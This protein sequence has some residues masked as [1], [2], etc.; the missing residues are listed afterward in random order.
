VTR[1]L[2]FT[3][4]SLAIVV[5]AALEIP[6]GVENARS[7]RRDLTAKVERDAVSVASLSESFVEHERAADLRAVR[8]L[9]RRYAASTGSRVVIVDANGLGIVDTNPPAA[10]RRSFASRPEFAIALQGRVATGTRHST[11]LGSSF[12]YVAVP[13]AS[14]GKILGAVRVTYP[15]ATLDARVRRYWLVLAA[16]AAVVLAVALIVGV[17]FARW[18]RRPLR[19]IERAAS[20]VSGGDLA[21]RAAIP[22]G[23]PELRA[24]TS[25]FNEMVVKLES[26]VAA[27][28]D[29]VAD[30]SHELRTPLTALRLRLENLESEIGTAGRPGLEAALTE[31][32]RLSELVESLLA[33]ARADAGGVAPTSV[34]LVAIARERVETWRA[35][36]EE[37]GVRLDLVETAVSPVR[38]GA[39]RVAQV[40]DNLL[41]NAVAASQRGGVVTV[42]VAAATGLVELRIRDTGPGLS[43]EEKTRAF[44]RFWRGASDRGGS[45]LGLAIVRRLVQADGAAIELTDARGGGLEV[46]VTFHSALS[47]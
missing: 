4:L 35:V 25:Q 20:Q 36:A 11:T 26:L 10:G 29:F 37:H 16:I 12:L 17:S 5:L 42:S 14:G 7:A 47:D 38:A 9:A 15:T 31:I 19:G 6:L 22:D 40:I 21:T 18:I 3:Y 45:G 13:I 44:D 30:A 33:L 23:P 28:R 39:D 43:D 2:L 34:D 32:E 24:L 1:R 8:L 41:A 27:Q 46:V